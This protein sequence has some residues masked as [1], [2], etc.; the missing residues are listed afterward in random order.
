MNFR[1]FDTIVKRN[2]FKRNMTNEEIKEELDKGISLL[3]H[4]INEFFI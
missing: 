3:T 2:S 4:S 1:I